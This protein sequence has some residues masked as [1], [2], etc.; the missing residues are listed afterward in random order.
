MFG[1]GVAKIIQE[2]AKIA[3]WCKDSHEVS[4][5]FSFHSVFQ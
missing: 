4:L 2:V 1:R 5:L 3:Q